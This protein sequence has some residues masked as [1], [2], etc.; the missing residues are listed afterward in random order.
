MKKRWLPFIA[1]CFVAAFFV[2]LWAGASNGT[3][4]QEIRQVVRDT[5]Q[6]TVAVVNADIG[7]EVDGVMH[8]YSA[9][10]I[11]TLGP[12]FVLVSPAMAYTGYNSG[13]Y[14]AI[15]TFPSDVSERV[16]SINTA[17]PQRI[18]LDFQ[19]N[20]NLT[21]RDF[22]ET[23]TRIID[24]QT[25]INTTLAQTFV[26]SIYNQFHHA[27]D[28][29]EVVFQNNLDAL[30]ALGIVYM[31]QFTAML[32][33]EQLPTIPL[34]PNAP[35]TSH[36]L[37]SVANIAERVAGMYLNSYRAASQSYL[38]MRYDLIR[39]TENF[40]VQENNWLSDLSA[41][42]T[43]S[44]VYGEALADFH[45]DVLAHNDHLNLWFTD[46][47]LWNTEL[48]EYQQDVTTW[49]YLLRDWHEDLGYWYAE[50]MAYIQSAEVFMN[51][52]EQSILDF[53]ENYNE[54]VIDMRH[55]H[56]FLDEHTRLLLH[57]AEQYD[58]NVVVVNSHK[59]DL[60][61][62][63]TD[64]EEYADSF[65]EL[66]AYMVHLID[67][68]TSIFHLP[69]IPDI[70]DFYYDPDGYKYALLDWQESLIDFAKQLPYFTDGSNWSNLDVALQNVPEFI[71]SVKLP[72]GLE[73]LNW[74]YCTIGELPVPVDVLPEPIYE[75]PQP[76][77][78]LPPLPEE[79]PPPHY[80]GVERPLMILHPTTLEVSQPE[81]PLVGPP[82]RPD[83]FWASLD[84]MHD[85]LLSFDVD[86][87]LTDYYRREVQN[88]I[89]D[90]DDYLYII[91]DDLSWQFDA[92]IG[93][94]MDV[95]SGYS[96]FLSDL[97]LDAINTEADSMERLRGKIYEFTGVAE[98]LGMDTQERLV[99]FA[100][101]M[102]ETRTPFG[103]N[104]NLVGFTVAP[105][106]FVAPP[107]R[108]TLALQTIDEP[109]ADG[110]RDYFL[111]VAIAASAVLA[112]TLLSYML[113][114]KKRNKVD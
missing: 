92:N 59:Q 94:L 4:H 51:W 97:R 17:N 29:V 76:P 108:E 10:I 50:Y 68:R 36:H 56:G 79:N 53:V 60:H 73:L 37:V 109:I 23:Y 105:V 71:P 5:V 57:F 16:V 9:A 78:P 13:I 72:Y 14:G 7:V 103:L 30:A 58:D 84:Q 12:E 69:T 3:E 26:S 47:Y 89:H 70:Y 82:P 87:F 8:N 96:E 88:L 11:D 44:V 62:W 86:S 111:I 75:F 91:R 41:W 74:D 64:L 102:P 46:A 22:L 24:L 25:A 113:G 63:H 77:E 95:R 45:D 112:F 90:F 18:R 100:N 114:R 6:T 28:Q 35:D 32:Q 98:A 40:P 110:Y 49:L 83:D 81:N 2:G 106:E 1:L 65:G 67:F 19:I 93:M 20:P 48:T 15:I 42:T 55:W 101:M 21:E 31:E 33:L 66:Q 54:S 52:V 107:L 27:Q 38:N 34:N 99:E 85:L 80:T 39:L 61:E 43:I 104:R